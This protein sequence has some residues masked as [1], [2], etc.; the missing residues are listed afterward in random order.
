M[1]RHR[2]TQVQVNRLPA[3]AEWI[4]RNSTGAQLS[5]MQSLSG[6]DDFKLLVKIVSDLKDYNVYRVFN[7]PVKDG[8]ELALLRAAARGEVAGLDALLYAIQGAKIE[9][10][11]R[12]KEKV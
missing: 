10:E 5:Y 11:R 2:A 7:D 12:R 3:V 4:L 8:Q 9:V 1:P 6:R